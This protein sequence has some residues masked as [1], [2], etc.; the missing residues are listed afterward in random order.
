VFDSWEA[1]ADVLN[2]RPLE[3]LRIAKALISSCAATPNLVAAPEM[4]GP[5]EDPH[6][7]HL[8]E[9]IGSGA[10]SRVSRCCDSRGR[11]FAVKRIGLSRLR[12]QGNYAQVE[13]MLHQEVAIHLSLQHP[14][15]AGLMDVVEG[16]EELRLVL[17]LCGGGSL[18]DILGVRKL[19][20]AQAANVFRQVAEGLHYIHVRG[21]AHRDLKPD[22][23]LVVD[24]LWAEDPDAA[25]EVKLAD[26][27]HS[28]VVD[29]F[30]V[31]SSSVGTPLYMAPEAFELE[32]IDARSADLWSLGVLLFVMLVG[33]CPFEGR[34]PELREAIQR[35]EFSF[36]ADPVPSETAQSLVRSLVK[37]QPSRR[38]SLD[39]CLVHPFIAPPAELG[40]RLLNDGLATSEDD[41]LE[42]YYILPVLSARQI[43]N[44]R[45]DL[46]RWM[47]KFRYSAM[48][49][50]SEVVAS[51]GLRSLADVERI[52]RA[53][54]EL[55]EVMS[56]HTHARRPARGNV[57]DLL[58]QKPEVS[59]GAISGG[60][61]CAGR[62]DPE[63]ACNQG[64]KRGEENEDE[65]TARMRRLA[66]RQKANPKWNFTGRSAGARTVNDQFRA[67]EET[68]ERS[69]RQAFQGRASRTRQEDVE[70]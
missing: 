53:H 28:K 27:G 20:E 24:R 42:E 61:K 67:Q 47:L 32:D 12:R 14:R 2:L 43:R 64:N 1:L 35:G 31:R 68:L 54:Q 4:F 60:E 13:E 63:S 52:K 50:G 15:I 30:F 33:S 41:C 36:Y 49:K 59:N 65:S 38:A 62:A 39:W 51:Y 26:F 29:D 10:T 9:K 55:L 21:I 11:A 69:R 44:L 37:R 5:E 6:R 34:G 7:Y 57:L 58:S 17:E 56:F 16:S 18:E 70:R 8:L 45:H 19:P 48:T 46:C 40:R 25:I 23:I 22:N 3:K 66:E